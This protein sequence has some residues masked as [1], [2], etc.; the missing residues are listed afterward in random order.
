MILKI[1][2][3]YFATASDDLWKTEYNNL[4]FHYIY[5]LL[6]HSL[7]YVNIRSMKLENL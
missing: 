4:V 2:F 1:S 5:Y 7:F 3:D 6:A